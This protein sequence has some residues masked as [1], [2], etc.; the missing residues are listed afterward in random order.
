MILHSESSAVKRKVVFITSE[1][2]TEEAKPHGNKS[3]MKDG[4]PEID[5]GNLR[6]TATG[7]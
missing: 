5:S 3:K 6:S 4:K 1:G 7:K 2:G